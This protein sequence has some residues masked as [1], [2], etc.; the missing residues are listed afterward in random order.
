MRRLLL[1]PIIM[2]L[3]A[4]EEY[5]PPDK[6]P[7]DTAVTAQP[8]APRNHNEAIARAL[9]EQIWNGFYKTNVING[10]HCTIIMHAKEGTYVHKAPWTQALK[11][12]FYYYFT[13]V[14]DPGWQVNGITGG[15]FTQQG[16]DYTV[17]AGTDTVI[18]IIEQQLAG[19]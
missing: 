18:D 10:A 3:A 5:I 16:A 19:G 14:P 1:I 2:C 9:G 11:Q 17:Y 15:V 7:K 12:G 6:L 8:S 4:C 13:V